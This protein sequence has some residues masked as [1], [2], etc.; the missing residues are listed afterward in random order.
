VVDEFRDASPDAR[1]SDVVFT[2][3]GRLWIADEAASTINGGVVVVRFPGSLYGPPFTMQKTLVYTGYGEYADFIYDTAATPTYL[4]KPRRLATNGTTR[5]VVADGG[6]NL[7]SILDAGYIGDDES[8]ALIANVPLPPGTLAN[9][10]AVIGDF[11]YVTSN[12]AAPASNFFRIDLS[13][14]HAMTALSL[15]APGETVAGIGRT[16]DGLKL[17]V[18]AGSAFFSSI[19]DVDAAT[20]TFTATIPAFGV[21]GSFPFAFY[22][23][24]I[25][26]NLPS[27]PTGGSGSGGGSN[28]G[29]CG[30]LGLEAALVLLAL[31]RLRKPRV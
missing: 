16:A 5:V 9:D 30:L 10:V 22:S 31:R 25:N 2:S 4:L 8:T 19:H 11:A 21:P 17:F 13:P 28:H 1:Y 26:T 18:G 29:D 15:G 7:V 27:T 12:A 24:N 3:N 6:S 20:F 14:P 23:S